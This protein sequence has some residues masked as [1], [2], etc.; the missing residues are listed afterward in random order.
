MSN[1]KELADI[2]KKIF[3]DYREDK[4]GLR[5]LRRI[6]MLNINLARRMQFEEVKLVRST[7]PFFK[8]SKGVSI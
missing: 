1:K 4:N 6:N 5:A 7:K 8:K 3:D 2:M